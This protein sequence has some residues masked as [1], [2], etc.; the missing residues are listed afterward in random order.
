MIRK[1]VQSTL[2]IIFSLFCNFSAFAQPD[3]KA[4]FNSNCASCHHPI[5]ESTGPAL[6]GTDQHP[7]G[8]E[9]VYKWVK[10]PS[11]VLASGDAHA[12]EL[13]DKY[14]VVMTPFPSLTNEDIDAIFTYINDFKVPVPAG[15]TPGAASA[16]APDSNGWL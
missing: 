13:V 11:A 14:K 2:L 15:P 4:L 3:G 5:K 12:K 6:Q 10:N 16:E 9:W 7:H 1:I 8:K